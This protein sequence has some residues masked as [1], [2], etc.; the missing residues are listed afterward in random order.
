[1]MYTYT[2]KCPLNYDKSKKVELQLSWALTEQGWTVGH[3]I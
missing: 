1:M 2:S 3:R